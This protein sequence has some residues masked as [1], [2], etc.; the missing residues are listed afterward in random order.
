MLTSY[1]ISLNKP[2][3]LLNN[4]KSYNLNPVLVNGIN[5]KKLCKEEIKRNTN[6]FYYNFGPKSAIG[7]AMSHIKTWKLFLETKDDMC[8]IFEDDVVFEKR[9]KYLNKYINNTPLNFDILLLGCLFCDDKINNIKINRFINKPLITA[10]L[11]AYVLTRNGA[12]KLVSLIENKINNHVD[13]MIFKLYYEGKINLYMISNRIAYQTSTNT[14]N[15][16]NASTYPYI[17]NKFF[18]IFEVDKMVRF[19]YVTSV[20][21]MRIYNFNISTITVL[22]LIFG[23][24][25]KLNKVGISKITLFFVLISLIDIIKFKNLS[26]ILFHYFILILPSII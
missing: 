12:H 1:V 5:G 3:E 14:C 8:I 16:E 24:I 9:F 13:V 11:H 2:I 26:N 10:G 25:F 18:S 17:L 22:F 20:H 6:S 23:F 7:C 15:S 19:N 21:F 4:I